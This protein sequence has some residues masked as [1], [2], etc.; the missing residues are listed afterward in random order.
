MAAVGGQVLG[1]LFGGKK[2]GTGQPLPPFDQWPKEVKELWLN[3]VVKGAPGVTTDRTYQ[4]GPLTRFGAPQ[5]PFDSQAL[6]KWQQYSDQQGGMFDPIMPK[7]PM[8]G[9]PDS[10]AQNPFQ[11][12][13]DM[14]Q[15]NMQMGFAP[16]KI[17]QMQIN[18][19]KNRMKGTA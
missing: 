11:A 8:A 2:K 17:A 1:G 9:S 6:W 13:I 15:Q 7:A 16:Q 19:L 12:Q 4:A 5:S 18:E 10:F 14:L 3:K